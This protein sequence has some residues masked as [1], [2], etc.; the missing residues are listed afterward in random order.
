MATERKIILQN[1][2]NVL[3][4]AREHGKLLATPFGED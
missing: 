1:Y 3:S 4:K 2:V